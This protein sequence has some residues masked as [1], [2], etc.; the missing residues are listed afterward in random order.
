MRFKRGSQHSR[1]S[2]SAPRT[3]SQPKMAS[4]RTLRDPDGPWPAVASQPSSPSRQLMRIS[5]QRE[6]RGDLTPRYF[7]VP[8]NWLGRITDSVGNGPQNYLATQHICWPDGEV[9]S[10]QIRDPAKLF[11]PNGKFPH[12]KKHSN[13]NML[14]LSD[15]RVKRLWLMEIWTLFIEIY[16]HLS[17]KIWL[18]V[19][20]KNVISK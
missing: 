7:A 4:D 6:A 14:L 13:K 1:R 9:S 11:W 10:N 19:H 15:L 8:I 18:N 2:S 20:S 16:Q 17:K 12:M 5:R 3:R